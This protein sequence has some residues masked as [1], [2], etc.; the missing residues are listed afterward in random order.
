LKIKG[1]LGSTGHAYVTT[2][3]TCERLRITGPIAFL[4]DLGATTTTLLE[5]DVQRLH[6]DVNGLQK[7][8]LPVTVCGGIIYPYKSPPVVLRFLTTDRKIQKEELQSIDILDPNKSN[9]RPAF[10]LLGLD[11]LKRYKVIYDKGKGIALEK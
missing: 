6:I 11:V 8:D 2:L 5:G 9:D 3:L 10:S 4:V 7:S 1:F